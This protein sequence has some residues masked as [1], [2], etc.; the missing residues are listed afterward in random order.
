M[1]YSIILHAVLEI[2]V[3]VNN[4]DIDV[5]V[6]PYCTT[7]T[8]ATDFCAQYCETSCNVIIYERKDWKCSQERNNISYL[9]MNYD[10]V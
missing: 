1:I 3:G 2:C 10:L 5:G 8:S 6:E 4:V 9:L 7:P